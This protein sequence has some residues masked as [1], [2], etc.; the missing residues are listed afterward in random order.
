MIESLVLFEAEGLDRDKEYEFRVFA[1][2][3]AGLGEPSVRSDTVVMKAKP[4]KI[5]F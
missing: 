1:K 3:Q 5:I 4:S 2:N